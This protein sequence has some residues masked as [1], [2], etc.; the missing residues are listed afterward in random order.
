MQTPEL[1]TLHTITPTP[2]PIQQVTSTAQI[3]TA[4]TPGAAGL[5]LMADKSLIIPPGEWQVVPTSIA[6]QLPPG[7]YGHITPRSGLAAKKSIDIGASIIDSDYTS[8]LKALLI[9]HAD[10]PFEVN[11]GDHMAQLIVE[12]YLVTLP[13]E[14]NTLT[15]TT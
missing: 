15:D 8:K 10:T 9:N 7:T 4:A 13:T 2:L 11:T 1:A 14:V 12:Q 5:D 3:P 6:I